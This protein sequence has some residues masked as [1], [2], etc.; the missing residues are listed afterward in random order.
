MSKNTRNTAFRKV[1]VDQFEEEKYEEEVVT[2]EGVTGPNDAEV[3]S[4]LS[5]GRHG[6]ALQ[7]VL[8]SP[9]VTSKNQAVKD[10]AVQSV[11][12]VLMAYK[13]SDIDAAVKA[14]DQTKQD[15]LMKYI[16]RGFELS[17]DGNGYGAQLLVWHDKVFAVAGLGSIVRTLAD[18]R[19][20]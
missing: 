15:V 2:D 9:P 10:K 16:Y 4:M 17:S 18:R 19:R 5:K 14:L 12:K 11:M 8:N 6:D 7:Y 20:V 13:S 1:D 3:Q